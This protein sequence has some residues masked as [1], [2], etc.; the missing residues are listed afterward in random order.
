MSDTS[1][2][3]CLFLPCSTAEIWALPR[4]ALAEIVTV[5]EAADQPPSSIHW[6]G[7][8]V[9]VLDLD[10]SGAARWREPRAG[11][12]LIAVLLGIQ[13]SG[14]RYLGVALRGQG[15]SMEPV[16]EAEIEDRP[17]L[18]LPGALG[19]FRWRDVTY[20]V[21]DLLTLQEQVGRDWLIEHSGVSASNA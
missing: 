3:Q 19:A 7:N 8:E 1:H 18:A 6:R 21:P 14:C 10:D 20:Q 2:R 17:D 11:T 13:G 15:L 4:N 16:P 12:G 9:P 5:K